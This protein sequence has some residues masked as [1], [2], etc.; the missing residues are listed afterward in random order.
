M[1]FFKT[2]FKLIGA[3]ILVLV[4]LGFYQAWNRT[5]EDRA[6][7]EQER[8]ERDKQREAERLVKAEEKAE[9]KRKGFHCLSGWSGS[10]PHVV[11]K[12]KQ[13]LNDPGSFDHIET[14][15]RPINENGQH[16]FVMK[17]RAKNA[18]GGLVISQAIGTYSNEN[19]EEISVVALN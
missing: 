6:V 10:Q 19:C 16:E 18:F 15:V 14:K 4:L 11:S 2:L 13:A 5:P 17:Y 1:R 3:L 8:A 7:Y 9:N 12:L